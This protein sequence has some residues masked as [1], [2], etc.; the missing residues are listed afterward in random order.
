MLLWQNSLTHS[1]TWWSRILP[2]KL[3]YPQLVKKFPAFFRTQKLIAHSQEPASCPYPK[4]DRSSQCAPSDFS[5]IRFNII[6]PSKPGSYKCSLSLKFAH[7]NPVCTSYRPHTCYTPCP[8]HFSWS[9]HQNNIWLEM[10]HVI[11]EVRGVVK[12]RTSV[13]CK[14]MAGCRIASGT[15]IEGCSVRTVYLTVDTNAGTLLVQLPRYRE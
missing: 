7:Q 12:Q 10:R 2:E 5:K 3:K 14:V 15:R 11:L 13:R 6:L 8:R 4:P 9:D 1:L